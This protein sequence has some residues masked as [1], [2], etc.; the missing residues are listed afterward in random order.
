MAKAAAAPRSSGHGVSG[1]GLALKGGSEALE[2][3]RGLD[4]V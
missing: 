2:R 4:K 3:P 1:S